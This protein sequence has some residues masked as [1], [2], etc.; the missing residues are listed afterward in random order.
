MDICPV[1]LVIVVVPNA[2]VLGPARL[3]D[4][5]TDTLFFTCPE[6]ESAL[7]VLN[8]LF[9]R[10]AGCRR[11]DEVEM[12]RHGNEFMQKKSLEPSV[13]EQ[14]IKEEAGQIVVPEHALPVIGD[15]GYEEGSDFLRGVSQGAPALKRGVFY[16]SFTRR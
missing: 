10:N 8:R 2:M 15:R 3:P 13:F 12:V 14:H 4:L 7:D 11:D 16:R 6:R 9:E 5:K 1:L